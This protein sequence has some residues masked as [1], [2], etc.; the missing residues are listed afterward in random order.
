MLQKAV[1]FHSYFIFWE[2]P[3]LRPQVLNRLAQL[4]NDNKPFM[5]L[6]HQSN[7]IKTIGFEH[8]P[9]FQY[10]CHFHLYKTEVNLCWVYF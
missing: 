8:L 6:G 2:E 9:L 3:Q 5:M 1:A 10:N 4:S 7:N